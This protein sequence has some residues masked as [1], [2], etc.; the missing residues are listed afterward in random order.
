M[1]F[2][3]PLLMSLLLML[4]TQMSY[5]QTSEVLPDKPNISFGIESERFYQ[6]TVVLELLRAAEEE[7]ETAVNEAYAEGY[8]TAMLHYA[9]DAAVYKAEAEV[10]R[11]ELVSANR[12][13]R[14]F[15]PAA[16]L[17]FTAGFLL[18]YSVTR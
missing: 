10:L 13:L 1:R 3:A 12:K 7:I 16:S 17:S 18:H 5:A 4:I 8:K 2:K 6:G 14:L 9:P 11:N 15:F